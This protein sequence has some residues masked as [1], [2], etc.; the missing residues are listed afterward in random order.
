MPANTPRLALPYPVG[1]DT[2]DVPRDVQALAIKLDGLPAL[3]PPLV[4]SLPGSPVDGQEVYFQTAAMATAGI[5]WHLRYRAAIADAYKWECL[6]GAPLQHEVTT[7]QNATT[8]NAW[9]NLAT[10][11]PL[12]TCPLAGIYNAY[13]GA[14]LSIGARINTAYVGSAIGDGIPINARFQLTSPDTGAAYAS[15]LTTA[16]VARARHTVA[17]GNIIKVRYQSTLAT[18][19]VAFLDRWLD[20]TPLRVG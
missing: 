2:V 8:T 14:T 17:A 11:G 3:S 9:V 7:Q 15:A 19:G 1:A 12:V 20:V 4:A 6:G 16:G 10:D 18:G 5:A 13:F